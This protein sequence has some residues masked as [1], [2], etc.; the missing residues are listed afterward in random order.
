MSVEFSILMV[1]ICLGAT[2]Q[3]GVGIGF[4][5]IAGPPMMILVV[6]STAIPVL[7]LL[8]TIVSAVATDRHVVRANSQTIP[9][10]IVGCLV[11]VVAGLV[12]YP[13]M[14]EAIVLVAYGVAFVLHSLKETQVL[15]FGSLL[16]G[17]V[18]VTLTGSLAGRVLGPRLPQSLTTRAIRMVSLIACCVLFHRAYTLT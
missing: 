11:G 15:L 6:T 14:N 10:V 9:I 1:A 4:S 13:L 5:I 18:A 7:L 8:N 12:V 2:L 3:V 17:F 16:I